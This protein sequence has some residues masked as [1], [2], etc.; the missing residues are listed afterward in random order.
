MLP[1][2]GNDSE[3]DK[4]EGLKEHIYS[5]NHATGD[6]HSHSGKFKKHNV[7]IADEW[8]S[9]DGDLSGL[10]EQM[11]RVPKKLSGAAKLF[12]TAAIFFVASLS[13][14]VFMFLSGGNLIKSENVGINIIGPVSVSGGEEM[15]FEVS[16]ENQNNVALESTYLLIEYPE[17]SR[18]P[19]DV[20]K[21]L[22]RYRELLGNIEPGQSSSK[23]ISAVLFGEE[24]QR[25]E[26]AIST[27]YRVRG[28]NALVKK[29]KLYEVIINSSPVSV[30]V[31]SVGTVSSGQ[32]T[33]FTVNIFSNSTSDIKN[34]LL[35]AEYPFGF[36]FESAVPKPSVGENTWNIG[37]LKP[38]A[39]QIIRLTGK[40]EGQDEEVRIFRF[41]IGTADKNDARFIG[42]PF[43]TA[44]KEIAIEKP[45]IGLELSLNGDTGRGYV[46]D[47]GKIIRA[48]VMWRNNT[49]DKI[50]G[51]KII[52]KLSGPAIKKGSVDA[53]GGFYRSSD[54][55][56]IW[57][58][59]NSRDFDILNPG[60]S[61]RV[62]FTFSTVGVADAVASIKNPE[63]LVEVSAEGNRV[64][65]NQVPQITT[66]SIN[67]EVKVSSVLGLYSRALY[68]TG[69]LVNSG[70]IPPKVDQETTYTVV[71]TLT[72]TSNDAGNV[73]VSANLPSYVKW[74]GSPNA[75]EGE[76]SYNPVSGQVIWR[77]GDVSAQA[78]YSK[79]VKEMTFQISLEPSSSQVGSTPTLMS[80]AEV[81]GDDKFTGARLSATAGGPIT[82][83]LSAD[84]A[85]GRGQGV[86]IE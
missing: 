61:G 84:P 82:T 49:P 76:L 10:D 85:F 79:P 51:A 12:M 78:G 57:D 22:T 64:G 81:T 71:W 72:N 75:S 69:V 44:S 16:V 68:H 6:V 29:S 7:E 8:K 47:S 3:K 27:E 56:I 35:K 50:T 65:E 19:K 4:I 46:A 77:A 36:V 83:E 20:T 52:A 55:S 53:E 38:N 80:V 58:Q 25:K 67:R 28:S 2:N 24:G 60:D 1:L 37:D 9:G 86:V 14:A 34:L 73:T 66:T 40:I 63:L 41:T 17:G 5:R 30:T 15:S 45:F 23:K 43:L 11:A 62:S 42:I 59:T 48:D 13:V 70:P 74:I 31:D 18:D 33:E 32:K 26:I 54:N 39:K 21:E